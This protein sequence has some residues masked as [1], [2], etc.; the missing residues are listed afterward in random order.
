MK[1]QIVSENG[2]TVVANSTTTI[3]CL[4]N[5]NDKT[6]EALSV[7]CAYNHITILS[8]QHQY[9][10]NVN[11]SQV[12]LL[13]A[14][15][16]SVTLQP[17]FT[18]H[19]SCQEIIKLPIQPINQWVCKIKHRIKLSKQY[20]K[21]QKQNQRI[22]RPHHPFFSSCGILPKINK[23]TKHIITAKYKCSQFK[24]PKVTFI[25]K[26]FKCKLNKAAGSKIL[27]NFNIY[28]TQHQKMIFA[29]LDFKCK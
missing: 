2:R 26:I 21:Q 8:Q 24:K 29:R 9:T 7:L 27:T 15:I 20:L 12:E 14:K 5:Y 13:C 10:I 28:P 1:L 23:Q 11:Y 6:L 16:S 17:F 3:K 18:H 19:P 25:D 4:H 22:N